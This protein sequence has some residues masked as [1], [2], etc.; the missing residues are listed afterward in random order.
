ML[1]ERHHGLKDRRLLDNAIAVLDFVP[2][3]FFVF[4]T[5]F[6]LEPVVERELVAG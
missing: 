3:E 5:D 2:A 4:V 1:C 6:E